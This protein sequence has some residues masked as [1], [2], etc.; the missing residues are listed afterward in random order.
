M[1]SQSPIYV[2]ARDVLLTESGF[3]PFLMSASQA[4]T[5]LPWAS[6]SVNFFSGGPFQPEVSRVSPTVLVQ[7]YPL[8]VT[9]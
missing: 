7:G 8:G 5:F 4:D 1:G 2:L 3:T 6:G 9:S